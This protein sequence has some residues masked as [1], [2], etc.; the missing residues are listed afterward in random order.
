[1]RAIILSLA[2]L[3]PATARASELDDTATALVSGLALPSVEAFSLSDDLAV[4]VELDGDLPRI[5]G[6]LLLARLAS[7]G[8]ESAFAIDPGP[9]ADARARDAGAEWL[10]LVRGEDRD[11]ALALFAEL[12]SIDRGIWSPPSDPSQVPIYATA[13]RRAILTASSIPR[14]VEPPPPGAPHP[15]RARL[16]GPALRIGSLDER[17]LALRACPLVDTD[18]DELVVLTPEALSVYSLANGRLRRT[19]R[20]EL[21]E[22]P[23]HATPAREPIGAIVCNGSKIAFGHS[24]LAG[25][26]VIEMSKKAELT[27]AGNLPGIPIAAL[28]DGRW[29]LAETEAG[30]SRYQKELIAKRGAETTK[31]TLGAPILD[32]VALAG[33]APSGWRLLAVTADYQ[34]V[35]LGDT[36]A[37]PERIGTSGVGISVF[38]LEGRPHVVATGASR[39]GGHDQLEL[40]GSGEPPARP[41]PVDGP[42][43]ATAAGRLRGAGLDLVAAAR[44]RDRTDLFLMT[45]WEPN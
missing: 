27:T 21:G 11:G 29:L 10:L 14:N 22:L 6:G 8:A 45:L 16:E 42:V 19:A 38:L 7:L 23:R 3:L 24:G 30:T 2:A 33:E 4:V 34:L 41:V 18:R 13:E 39:D 9:N 43:Y 17:V 28:P 40:Y 37:A 15:D 44:A 1:M 12:R 35:R 5:L 25:G 36:L 32:A 31:V 20:Y 26:H